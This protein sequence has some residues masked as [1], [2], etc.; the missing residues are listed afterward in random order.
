MHPNSLLFLCIAQTLLSFSTYIKL[1]I[2][3]LL[4]SFCGLDRHCCHS[5][6]SLLQIETPLSCFYALYRPCS[7]SQQSLLHN[8]ALFC[9]FLYCTDHTP[10]LNSH[11]CL[12][13]LYFAFLHCRDLP[14]TLNSHYCVSEFY[15][16]LC[17]YCTG[18]TLKLNRHYCLCELYSAFS[19]LHRPCSHS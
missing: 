4:S 8:Q 2:R 18:Y 10:N 12:C 11:Y 15:S 19:A 1:C 13:D 5:R 3:A 6:Q 14:L 7:H 9:S 17:L 16:A